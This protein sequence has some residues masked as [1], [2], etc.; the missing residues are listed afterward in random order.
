[1][2][3][4]YF[5]TS[6]RDVRMS[7]GWLRN[8]LLLSLV[9]LVPIIGS[10]V[11][12]GYVYGW[13][14]DIA[15]G[16]RTPMPEHIRSAGR[17]R[18][19]QRGMHLFV[20]E[21]VF[22][23][24]P[25]L[26]ALLFGIL[27]NNGLATWAGSWQS[28]VPVDVDLLIQRTVTVLCY[29]FALIVIPFILVGWMRAT[30]YGRLSA[31]F[32]ISRIWSMMRYRL[33]GLLRIAGILLVLLCAIVV[34]AM[35]YILGVG[36]LGAAYS[37]ITLLHGG[38]VDWNYFASGVMPVAIAVLPVLV[39]AVAV[40]HTFAYVIIARSLGYW[41]AQFDVPHW[42]GQDDPMP[43]ERQGVAGSE[44]GAADEVPVRA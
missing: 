30:I 5:A 10:M 4:G 23:A 20:L 14:R 33:S 37:A 35:L 32:Q 11:L 41:T 22:L 3:R 17:D 29:V 12:L 42:Q 1:M 16:V 24:V 19:M 40:L 38:Q 31:G 8:L 21:M 34:L 7:K 18:M 36:L 6:W 9:S 27:F 39:Y 13:A 43:F 15:W 25:A 2:K 26:F 44:E 28:L